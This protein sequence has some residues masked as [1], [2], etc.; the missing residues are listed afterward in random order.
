MNTKSFHSSISHHICYRQISVATKLKNILKMVISFRVVKFYISEYLSTTL[1]SFFIN[2]NLPASSI[3][4]YMSI[5]LVH[6]TFL[7][8]TSFNFTSVTFNISVI[9]QRSDTQICTC[10]STSNCKDLHIVSCLY[11]WRPHLLLL[12][13]CHT[14]NGFH[15][16]HVSCDVIPT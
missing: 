14:E 6:T 16:S 2:T 11:A 3:H 7:H 8:P 4:Q 9:S 1:F 13:R 12:S 10:K 15:H 5:I